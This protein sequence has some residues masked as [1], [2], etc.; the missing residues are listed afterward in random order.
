MSS[1]SSSS[2]N[3][4]FALREKPQWSTAISDGVLGFLTLY[5]V[6]L[7]VGTAAGTYVQTGRGQMVGMWQYIAAFAIGLTGAAASVGQRT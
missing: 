5:S 2:S 1:K 6:S 7:L 4:K 3:N